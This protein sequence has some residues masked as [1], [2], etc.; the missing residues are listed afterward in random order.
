MSAVKPRMASQ[1]FILV[2][3]AGPL[4]ALAIAD[5]LG[6]AIQSFG[7][8][9]VPNAVLQECVLNLSEPGAASIRNAI[10]NLSITPIADTEIA[11]LDP[12]FALGLGSGEQAVL[13]Y[14]LQKNYVALIDDKKA[15]LMALRLGIATVRT[16]AVL[17]A[18]KKAGH[19]ASV[20]PALQIWREHGYFL[21]DTVTNQLLMSAGEK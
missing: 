17:L 20:K 9:L 6:P 11:N 21:S 16:G 1:K 3:D 18:L 15:H 2:V 7:N 13:A 8:L 5:L 12:A 19:I 10:Q 4:I 14:A